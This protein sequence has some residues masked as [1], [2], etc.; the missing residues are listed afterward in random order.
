MP[1]SKP[2][3]AVWAL[4]VAID[5]GRWRRPSGA[6]QMLGYVGFALRVQ[7]GCHERV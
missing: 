2:L 7:F 1:L 6:V 4:N 3:G 5:R